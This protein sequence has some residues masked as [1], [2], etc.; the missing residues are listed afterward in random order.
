VSTQTYQNGGVGYLPAE[1]RRMAAA[2]DE[3]RRSDVTTGA[4][5]EALLDGLVGEARRDRTELIVWLRNRGFTVDQ[6]GASLTPM[7]LPANRLIG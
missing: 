6:I 3:Q 2:G 1:R 4:R 5:L 7:M